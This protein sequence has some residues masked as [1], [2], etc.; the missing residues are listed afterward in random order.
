M[1]VHSDH[2]IHTGESFTPQPAGL[3]SCAA[4]EMHRA[5]R[6]NGCM[7]AFSDD[8]TS[9][10]DGS[11]SGGAFGF[12]RVQQALRTS[13]LRKRGLKERSRDETLFNSA[14]R[15]SRPGLNDSNA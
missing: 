13:A 12:V 10:Q 15:S 7:Q 8:P 5:R 1:R 3:Q 4:T 14:H 2:L 11:E 6:N 9:C